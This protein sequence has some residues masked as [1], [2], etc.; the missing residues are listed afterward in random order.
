VSAA[1]GEVCAALDVGSNSVK[2]LIGSLGPDGRVDVRH[3][4][5]VVTKLSEGV[6][7][8][9]TLLPAASARTL[10]VL[11]R[12]AEACRT[13]GVSRTAAVGTAVLRDARDADAF[14]AQARALGFDIEVIDGDTE[15]YVVRLAALR[16]LPGTPDDAVVIDIGGGSSELSWVTGRESTE[17]GVVRLTERHV[18]RDPAG[19]DVLEALRAVVRARLDRLALPA[20]SEI[21]IGSSATCAVLARL[22]LALDRHDRDRI[23]G[24]EIPTEALVARASQLAL[25]DLEG[26]RALSG[27]DRTR[28]DVILAGTVVLEQTALRLGARAL[29]INDRGTRFGV[30][31]RAF[32]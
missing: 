1:P 31:H 25:L 13:F 11:A 16:E 29:R 28:A 5:V 24:H 6:D 7:A 17:L 15:A 3:E 2:L 27:M 20:R 4:E 26:R 22:D 32:G 14:R 19:A 10:A 30:F 12:Y 8:R 18:P 21:L 23:H 9:G